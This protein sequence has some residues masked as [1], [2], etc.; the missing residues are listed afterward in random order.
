MDKG[1]EDSQL[2]Y[3][4]GGKELPHGRE[5]GSWGRPGRRRERMPAARK[6]WDKQKVGSGG[7]PFPDLMLGV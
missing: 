4:R 3:A 1:G 7:Q 2:V 5:R 6:I